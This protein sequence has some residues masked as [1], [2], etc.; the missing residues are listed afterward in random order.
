MK[1]YEARQDIIVQRRKEIEER[2]EERRR[3]P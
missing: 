1:G 2:H 3:Q